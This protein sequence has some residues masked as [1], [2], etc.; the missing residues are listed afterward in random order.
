MF[1]SAEFVEFTLE[2]EYVIFSEIVSKQLKT[3]QLALRTIG[4][5]PSIVVAGRFAEKTAEWPTRLKMS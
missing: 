2:V 3:G 5:G 1:L 4:G